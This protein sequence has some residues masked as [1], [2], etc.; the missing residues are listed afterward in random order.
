MLNDVSRTFYKSGKV[1]VERRYADGVQQGINR[2]YHDS[3]MNNVALE[4]L[5]INDKLEGV[6]KLFD[7]AG[8][9]RVKDDYNNGELL[10]RIRYDYQGKFESEEKNLLDYFENGSLKEEIFLENGKRENASRMY[11]ENGYL[12]E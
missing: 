3:N 5:F 2:I 10:N 4:A 12:K 6:V 1:E 11:Y 7:M 9:L 8:S